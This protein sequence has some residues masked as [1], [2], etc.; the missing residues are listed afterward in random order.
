METDKGQ[1]AFFT[2]RLMQWHDT[3]NNRSLPWKE[4]K[5][6]YRIWLSEIILQQTRSEQGRPYYLNFTTTYPTIQDLADAPDEAAFRIWQGLGYYNRCKNMLATARYIA[7]DLGGKFPQSYEGLLAL[8]GIG[9]YT[10]AAIGSFAFGLPHAVVDG[11]V[12]RVLSRYFGI[13][14]PSDSTEGKKL[15]FELANELL[16]KKRSAAYNQAIMD[17]GAT[18]CTPAAPKCHICPVQEKCVAYHNGLIALLPVRSKKQAV[19]NR[20]FNYILFTSGDDVWIMKRDG[21]DIWQNLYEL[22]LYESDQTITKQQL[23]KKIKESV[24]ISS[25]LEY[26]GVLTQRL[27]HQLIEIKFY[28]MEIS[29]TLKP[30]E[31]EGRW[32]NQSMLKNFAFPKSIVSFLEKKL[33]F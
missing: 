20:Y 17:H 31:N 30:P 19:R 5:D 27:T 9:P 12:Y 6:P 24:D 25:E 26:E 8:K 33:Y 16:D 18:V 1:K 29:T 15:F 2:K 14:V 11:N 28:S 32:V 3:E 7:H 21:K 22:Y 13:E 23:A 4:E 10:A